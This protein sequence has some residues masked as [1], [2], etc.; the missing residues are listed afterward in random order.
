MNL[1]QLFKLASLGEMVPVAGSGVK[2]EMV[3][4]QHHVMF[5]SLV[6]ADPQSWNADIELRRVRMKEC[7]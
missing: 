3:K 6:E 5:V 4:S 2:F 7:G 1:S